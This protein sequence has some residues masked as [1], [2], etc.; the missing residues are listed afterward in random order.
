MKFLV[1]VLK[2]ANKTQ[3]EEIIKYLNELLCNKNFY[4]KRLFY[5]FIE[6]AFEI[7]SSKFIKECTLFDSIMKLFYETS[8]VNLARFFRI[9]PEFYPF[10]IDNDV[11]TEFYISSRMEIIKKS[12]LFKD[13]E[14]VKVK[15]DFNIAL[16]KYGKAD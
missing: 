16:K 5:T 3:Q 12:E 11:G 2:Y 10:L 6:Q 4:V 9:L 14:L 13:S 7:L 15:M 8:S 1:K